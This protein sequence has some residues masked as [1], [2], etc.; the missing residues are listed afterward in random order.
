MTVREVFPL[1]FNYKIF[2]ISLANAQWKMSLPLSRQGHLFDMIIQ[3][4]S[5]RLLHEQLHVQ[6]DHKMPTDRQG[7]V[8]V[9]ETLGKALL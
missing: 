4:N 9:L 1:C 7:L 8:E 5:N 3:L 6:V 2:I